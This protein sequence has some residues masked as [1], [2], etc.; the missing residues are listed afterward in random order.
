MNGK[1]GKVSC[2]ADEKEQKKAYKKPEFRIYGDIR[3]VTKGGATS[4]VSDSG[5]NS[6]SPP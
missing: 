1:D 6:M 2:D 5:Q 4:T 3:A